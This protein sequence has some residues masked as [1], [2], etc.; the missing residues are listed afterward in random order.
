MGAGLGLLISIS[1]GAAYV[2]LVC[3]PG[4][5]ADLCL[6]FFDSFIAVWFTKATD[7]WS[8]SEGLWE[9]EIFVEY[10]CSTS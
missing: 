5:E 2:S 8:K 6:F 10:N 9:G 4:G 3:P 1:I 7:L